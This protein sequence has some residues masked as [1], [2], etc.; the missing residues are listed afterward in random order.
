[1]KIFKWTTRALALLILLFGLLFYF[2]YGNPLP[3]ISADY[4]VFDNLW[5]SIFPIMFVGLALGWWYE[6]IAG[7][8]ITISLFIGFVGSIILGEGIA[9][10]MLVPFIVGVMYLIVGYKK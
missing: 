2:G 9:W 3:F 6:K 7:Y 10:H 4:T 5:L 1:M 8:L